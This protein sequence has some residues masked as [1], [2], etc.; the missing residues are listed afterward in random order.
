MDRAP[1]PSEDS[2][3]RVSLRKA[4]TLEHRLATATGELRLRAKVEVPAFDERP[5]ETVAAAR[6]R[7]L[8]ELD[9]A[10]SLDAVRY[11]LRAA[12]GRVNAAAGIDELLA[13]RAQLGAGLKRLQDQLKDIEPAEERQLV[14][15]LKAAQRWLGEDGL[16][17]PRRNAAGAWGG[18]TERR[19]TWQA[20]KAF[21]ERVG[22]RP[23]VLSP[24]APGGPCSA[25]VRGWRP[26]P[27]ASCV[28][29]LARCLSSF[30]PLSLAARA[31]PPETT[32]PI[33]APQRC[34]ASTAPSSKAR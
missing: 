13:R 24:D 3:M 2:I 19:R 18:C 6:A 1:L 20:W 21:S 33:P 32:G 22:S 12:I 11:R 26:L 34:A 5:M 23:K 28:L 25:G 8:A 4:A 14:A 16:L 9:R 29:P 30:R 10:E 17:A 15:Q 31:Q 7:L 27:F